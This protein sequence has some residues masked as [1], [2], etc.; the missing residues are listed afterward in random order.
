[1]LLPDCYDP[2]CQEDQRQLEWDEFA[3]TL[4]VCTLCRRRLYPGDRFHTASHEIV[5]QSCKL[6]LDDNEDIVEVE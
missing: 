2:A 5:C 6:E 3:D 4:P 1:M